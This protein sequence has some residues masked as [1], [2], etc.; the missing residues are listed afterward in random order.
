MW[1][2]WA[3]FFATA[4]GVALGIPAGYFLN[5]WIE[6]RR[7]REERNADIERLS[8][9]LLAVRA[10]VERNQAALSEL[11][12]FATRSELPIGINLDVA[13]WEMVK[14]DIQ[15]LVP[16]HERVLIALYFEDI[17]QISDLIALLIDHSVGVNS[18][19]ANSR[20]MAEPLRTLIERRASAAIV[21]GAAIFEAIEIAS[22]GKV[23]IGDIHG[24]SPETGWAP[25]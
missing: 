12:R 2:S 8:V 3:A 6:A 16:G 22:D 14:L 19:V 15:R 7:S 17:H 1:W 25:V 11:A 13:A 24:P 10:D 21:K 5:R 20:Q 4:S 23:L 9:A 18:A